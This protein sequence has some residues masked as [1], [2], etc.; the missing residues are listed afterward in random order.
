M[1][2]DEKIAALERRV[3]ALESRLAP[4]EAGGRG[5]GVESAVDEMVAGALLRGQ[6][7]Q[8][9][10]NGVFGLAPGLAGR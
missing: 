3:S 2:A 6:R 7:T 4:A 9:A 8:G 5:A 10:L 1:D